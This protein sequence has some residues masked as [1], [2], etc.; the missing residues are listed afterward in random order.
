LNSPP[1]TAASLRGKVVLVDFWTYSYINCL[2]ALPY[3]KA[4]PQKYKDQGLVVIGVHAPEFAFEKSVDNVKKAV[5]SLGIAYPVAIDNNYAIWQ[6]GLL[7]S[8]ADERGRRK[9]ESD[10]RDGGSRSFSSPPVPC[11][12]SRG[13]SASRR[14][15]GSKRWM[16]ERSVRTTQPFE[17]RKDVFDFLAVRLEEARQLKVLAQ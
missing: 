6:T 10:I 14:S 2:R 12:N 13:G 16:K 1:L 17:R 7:G 5:T 3:V 4:W 9:V 15:A 11:N 8:G